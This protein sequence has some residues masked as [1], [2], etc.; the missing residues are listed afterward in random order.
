MT[1]YLFGQFTL[2]HLAKIKRGVNLFNKQMYWECH[3]DLEHH[4]LEDRGDN[5]RYVYWAIIQVAA[6]MIH[7]D[8]KNIA[9]ATGM[10]SKAKDKILFIEQKKIETDVLFKFVDWKKFKNLVQ[11]VPEEAPLESFMN[12]FEYRFP[13]VNLWPVEEVDY[14]KEH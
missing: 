3:E 2:E 13:N 11:L 12:L 7:V 10:I 8:R 5:A 6:C 4:W 9:G 1:Q 14:D